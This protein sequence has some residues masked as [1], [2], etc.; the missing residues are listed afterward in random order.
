MATRRLGCSFEFQ[1]SEMNKKI[2]TALLAL[3]AMAGQ[4]Q[5]AS[6]YWIAAD[7]ALVAGNTDSTFYYLNLFKERFGRQYAA[8]YTTFL[9]DEDYRILHNDARWTAFMDS[10][11]TYKHEAE[12]KQEIVYPRK[13]VVKDSNAPIVNHY[14]IHLDIDVERK[15][16]AVTA[17]AQIELKGREDMDFTLWRYCNQPYP[18]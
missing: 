12:D 3:V 11:R 17:T 7:K 10:M 15:T 8:A 16:L 5:T 4:G 18:L 6:D 1:E 9:T 14:D 2:I 13:M